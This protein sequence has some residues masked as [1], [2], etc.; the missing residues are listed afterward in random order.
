MPSG[1]FNSFF[2][3]GLTKNGQIPSVSD[4]LRPIMEADSTPLAQPACT[5]SGERLS[6]MNPNP[7]AMNDMAY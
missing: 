3:D 2:N 4:D 7:S 6:G 5:L 1:S